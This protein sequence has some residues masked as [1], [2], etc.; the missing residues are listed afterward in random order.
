[1]GPPSSFGTHH[2]AMLFKIRASPQSHDSGCVSPNE[3][4]FDLS[5]FVAQPRA[6]QHQ[7]PIIT[8]R[9]LIDA[10]C[11][12]L[13]TIV[14]Y[15][16]EYEAI[17]CDRSEMY[18]SVSMFGK[19]LPDFEIQGRKLDGVRQK[20]VICI[21]NRAVKTANAKLW[22]DSFPVEIHAVTPKVL[23]LD[24]LIEPRQDRSIAIHKINRWESGKPIYDD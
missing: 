14:D 15:A 7:I 19:I 5:A 22:S 12:Y 9:D 4:D 6:K 2:F 16:H 18:T 20:V 21:A 8:L 10:L 11:L 24:V 3:K 1:M 13:P 17:E 23:H